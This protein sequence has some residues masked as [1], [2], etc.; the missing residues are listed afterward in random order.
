M[1]WS[2][3]YDNSDEIS[4]NCKIPRA[5][6]LT[7]GTITANCSV[8]AGGRGFY[9]LTVETKNEFEVEMKSFK[10]MTSAEGV[11]A[12]DQSYFS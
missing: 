2:K 12:A 11:R 1:D 4:E 7:F 3:C 8:P 10:V 9:S 6:G 5:Y